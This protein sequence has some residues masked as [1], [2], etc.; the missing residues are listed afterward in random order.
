M[1]RVNV[2]ISH[3]LGPTRASTAFLYDGNISRFI[4]NSR[5]WFTLLIT[6]TK[7]TPKIILYQ[8]VYILLLLRIYTFI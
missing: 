4:R 2:L 5:Q 1:K 8:T 7:I 6:V 3:T